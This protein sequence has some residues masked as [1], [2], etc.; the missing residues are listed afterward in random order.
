MTGPRTPLVHPHR[1]RGRLLLP[2]LLVIIGLSPLA[3]TGDQPT[4]STLGNSSISPA[5]HH[6]YL[7]VDAADAS[8]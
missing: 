6:P 2:F 4:E 3:C 5:V 1:R 8:A 7:T